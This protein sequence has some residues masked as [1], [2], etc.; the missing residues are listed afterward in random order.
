MK[1]TKLFY[2]IA[3]TVFLQ[4]CCREY[5]CSLAPLQIDV[6][7]MSDSSIQQSTLLGYAKGQTHTTPIF[8]QSWSNSWHDEQ[9]LYIN[10]MMYDYAYLI[11]QDTVWI[12]S[13][14]ATQTYTKICGLFPSKVDIQSCDITATII[15][16]NVT[17]E[18]NTIHVY[19]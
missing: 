10:D 2:L 16:K 4:S 18:G 17:K 3:T 11:N 12:T 8:S 5:S 14:M 6:Q 9:T 19:P 1:P 7:A 15:G 13:L